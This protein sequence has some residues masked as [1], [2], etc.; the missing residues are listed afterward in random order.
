ML[1]LLP[2]V[3]IVFGSGFQLLLLFIVTYLAVLT[4]VTVLCLRRRELNLTNRRLLS[5]GFE[6]LVC[7][8]IAI[9]TLRKITYR[10]GLICDPVLFAKKKF[11]RDEFSTLIGDVC[12]RIDEQLGWLEESGSEHKALI[13]YR[14]RVKSMVR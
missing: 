14:Y 6:C 4:V 12:E 13:A 2:C 9:D 8:P 1:L 11:T 5:I 7:P 10:S 3:L